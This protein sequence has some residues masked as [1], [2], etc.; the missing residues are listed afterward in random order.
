MAK[1]IKAKTFSQEKKEAYLEHL[2]Q[3]LRRGEAATSIGMTRHGVAY[4]YYRDPE[5]MAQI[6]QAELDACE[7]VESALF[8][9]ACDGNVIACQVWLYN[10][11]PHQWKDKRNLNMTVND[12]DIDREIEQQLEALAQ[13]EKNG[14][15]GRA[16]AKG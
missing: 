14:H 6:E 11:K 15:A 13:R 3:G 4:H 5:F 7:K 16:Q 2:R 10:R 12:D 1:T 8:K 9:A